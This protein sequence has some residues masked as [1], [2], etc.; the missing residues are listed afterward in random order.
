M[1]NSR[2]YYVLTLDGQ[3]VSAGDA[4]CLHLNKEEVKTLE[5]TVPEQRFLFG[6]LARPAPTVDEVA[7]KLVYTDLQHLPP[8]E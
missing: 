5:Q 8:K 4:L 7:W 6:L 2:E 1:G 3:L